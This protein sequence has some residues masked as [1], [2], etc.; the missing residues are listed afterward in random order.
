MIDIR[1]DGCGKAFRIAAE[2]HGKQV[3]CTECG[4]VFSAIP[5]SSIQPPTIGRTIA[6]SVSRDAPTHY[7][8]P[9]HAAGHASNPHRVS[10][11]ID[12]HIHGDDM[13]YV[14]VTLDPGEMAIA[15]AGS[16]MFMTDGIEMQTMFG[17]PSKR[18]T[19]GFWDRVVHAG[20]RA[21]TG[22]SMFITTYT[23]IR[24]SGR[25]VVAFA[26]PYPG[27]IIPLHLDQWNGEIICQKD[28][29]LCGAKGIEISIA[30]Q[31]K[32]ATAL[33]GGEGF[34][35]Q[36]L[37]GDG[38]ALVHASGTMVHRVLSTGER[39]RLDTGC[40]MAVG[41]SVHYDIE[42]VGGIKNALFG[43]EGL[44]LATLTGP[45]PIWLQSLPFSRV[46]GRILRSARGIG[47]KE[48]GSVLNH[49]G[50]IGSLFMGDRS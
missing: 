4:V 24:S 23:N 1:C 28:A 31:K 49:L 7:Y 11:E 19:S 6:S 39:L 17:D 29:F 34:I 12:Y 35:M 21:I 13:Q 50:G 46:A 40:L 47:G 37:R 42:Y 41:P 8:A 5:F 2:H 18:G 48:E 20:K 27:K 3:R 9:T 30:F 45:G 38:I 32:I 16:M 14:E 10:D 15:E 33:F 43:G 25:E 44:F 36:R 22:E 26:A